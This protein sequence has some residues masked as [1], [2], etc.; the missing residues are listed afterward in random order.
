MCDVLTD[1]F[2]HLDAD[3]NDIVRI[4]P[5]ASISP[6]IAAPENKPWYCSGLVIEKIRKFHDKCAAVPT[7]N[8]ANERFK[9]HR[10]SLRKYL[11]SNNLCDRE[12]YTG[13]VHFG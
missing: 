9:E 13:N 8:G 11:Q 4:T 3:L 5:K 6:T 2:Y 1:A 10:E 12:E 7:D